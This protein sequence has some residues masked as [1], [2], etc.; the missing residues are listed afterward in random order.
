MTT[1]GDRENNTRRAIE[2]LWVEIAALDEGLEELLDFQDPEERDF[3]IVQMTVTEAVEFLNRLNWRIFCV[4]RDEIPYPHPDES[5]Y[6]T[7]AREIAH[8]RSRHI[9]PPR[10]GREYS[11]T[12][13][14]V[15]EGGVEYRGV[16]IQLRRVNRPTPTQTYRLTPRELETQIRQREEQAESRRV[17]RR[18]GHAA[19]LPLASDSKDTDLFG[20][21]E[22]DDD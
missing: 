8:R 5:Q 2:R 17:R 13:G 20:S 15:S 4:T 3:G 22:G 21:D 18:V 1:R 10:V 16:P 11:Q 7:W 19:P 12:P 14:Q 6:V 9:A